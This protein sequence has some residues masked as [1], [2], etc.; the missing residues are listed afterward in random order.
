MPRP[1]TLFTGQWADLPFEEV[2]RLASGW[3][4]DGLEI[5]CWGDH[6]EVDRALADDSYIPAKKAMLDKYGLSVYAISNHLVG[7]AVCDHPID[8][9]HKGILPSRLW[10]DGEPEG[11]RQ[12]AADEMKDTARAARALG[13]DVVVGFT[14]SS[15]W[16]TLAMFPPVPTSMLDDGY[17]DFADRWNPILD[18]FDEVG[19]RFA[20]EVHPSEIAYDYYT[21][22]RTLEAIGHRTAFGLNWDPSHMVWQGIDPANFILD[23]ADRIYHVD[24]KDTKVRMGDGR[25]GIVSSHLGWADPHR[26][27]DFVSTGHGDVPWED[28][29]RALNAIGY[30]G[31]ISVEW[32]DA[33]MDRLI[34][35]AEAI[36]FVRRLAFDKPSASF[37]AAFSSE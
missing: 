33:G 12:R 14:G 30:D 31:P 11:V 1:I 26:G 34:G 18:V 27:W 36:G 20:H 10:G 15:I 35:A 37:D 7:Q 3:G 23:F 8:I 32:E 25:R 9:R 28:C 29:F 19:V 5:A 4:Y 21:T 6:F 22:K 17:R 16:H 24:C 13:V 2:C